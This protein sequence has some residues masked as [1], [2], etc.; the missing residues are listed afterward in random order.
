M[1]ADYSQTT[2]CWKVDGQ[3][4]LARW[5]LQSP[6]L[7]AQTVLHFGQGKGWAEDD[8]D[9]AR[10]LYPSFLCGFMPVCLEVTH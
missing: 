9:A 10:S 7:D 4:L 8:W 5:W 6:I 2:I 1:P 3:F